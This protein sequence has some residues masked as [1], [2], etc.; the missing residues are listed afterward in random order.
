MAAFLA[1]W[2]SKYVFLGFPVD[3]VNQR[4]FPLAVALSSGR[5]FPLAPIYLGNL[6][7][8]LD[9]IGESFTRSMG[10]KCFVDIVFL[11]QFLCERF[12][13]WAP[14]PLKTHSA[15]D[16]VSMPHR[17]WRWNKT[18]SAV[19]LADFIDREDAFVFRP[20][21]TL[22]EKLTQEAFL[23]NEPTASVV[24]PSQ[25]PLDDERIWERLTVTL[26]DKLPYFIEAY[27]RTS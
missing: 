19:P 15:V 14:L 11:Q 22:V 4:L 8:R 20:Y 3:F 17:A 25:L 1:Y 6:Y 2:L 7:Y 12:P 10:H 23:L 21:T 13:N 5:R 16:E 9:L 27:D 24:Q 26:W 18:S